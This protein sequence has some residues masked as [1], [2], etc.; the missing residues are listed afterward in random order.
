MRSFPSIAFTPQQVLPEV[1]A[2]HPGPRAHRNSFLSGHA[3]VPGEGI[4]PL[5][6]R[7]RYTSPAGQHRELFAEGQPDRQDVRH[8]FAVAHFLRQ[9]PAGHCPSRFLEVFSKAT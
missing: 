5:D 6:R 1:H 3:G 8:L 9:Q 2:A 4:G 7:R